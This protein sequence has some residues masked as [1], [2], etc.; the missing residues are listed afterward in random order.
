MKTLKMDMGVPSLL[1][2]W[3]EMTQLEPAGPLVGLMMDSRSHN[4]EY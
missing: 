4:K 1:F 2:V 3:P